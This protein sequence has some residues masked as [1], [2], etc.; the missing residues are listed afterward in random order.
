[1]EEITY[2]DYLKVDM[3]IG[4]II[5]AVDNIRARVPAYILN[6][7]FGEQIGMKISS[8]QITQNYTKS[9]L[10]GKQI[11]AI[12]NFP[13]KKIAGIKSEVL[14]LAGVSNKYGSTLLCPTNP[15][16]VGSTVR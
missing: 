11:A 7:D 10:I 15:I 13:V 8:A 1:M 12:I 5:S 3:R 9:E 14:L 2:S 4:T 16:E 6:I